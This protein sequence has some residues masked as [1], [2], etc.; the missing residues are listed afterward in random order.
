MTPTLPSARATLPS[1]RASTGPRGPAAREP[2]PCCQGIR[3]ADW[4]ISCPEVLFHDLHASA[5]ERLYLTCLSQPD[6][7]IWQSVSERIWCNMGPALPCLKTAA[8]CTLAATCEAEGRSHNELSTDC[9]HHAFMLSFELMLQVLRQRQSLHPICKLFL[10]CDRNR[11]DLIPESCC[12]LLQTCRGGA[13]DAVLLSLPE[14]FSCRA[15][16]A[17]VTS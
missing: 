12:C 11:C 14:V 2:P 7:S 10:P 17:T 4:P 5:V 8:G 16:P 9:S 6:G 1:R 13:R 3:T 15:A